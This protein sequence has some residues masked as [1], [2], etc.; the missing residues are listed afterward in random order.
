V[1]SWHGPD[2]ATTDGPAGAAAHAYLS[3]PPTLIG[4]GTAEIQLN[5]IGERVLGLPRD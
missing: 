3:C 2:A 4:G 5:V 1:W